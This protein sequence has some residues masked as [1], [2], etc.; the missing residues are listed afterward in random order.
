MTLQSEEERARLRLVF[1]C[2]CII[3]G[4][5]YNRIASDVKCFN[6]S[7]MLHSF[8]SSLLWLVSTEDFLLI[9]EYF[10]IHI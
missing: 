2:V 9:I 5:I 7:C 3:M 4:G 1:H 6:V 10:N 8:D